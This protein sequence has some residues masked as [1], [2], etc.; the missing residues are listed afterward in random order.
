[1]RTAFSNLRSAAT[2]RNRTVATHHDF[3][4]NF[5]PFSFRGSPPARRAESKTF[6]RRDVAL[7]KSTGRK[8][9]QGEKR[10]PACHRSTSARTQDR[11]TVK[12]CAVLTPD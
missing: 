9:S 10:G 2:A 11:E 1:M 3:A 6:F 8:R 5:C 7:L 4:P 12:T